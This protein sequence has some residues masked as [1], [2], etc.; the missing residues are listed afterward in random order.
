MKEKKKMFNDILGEP[1]EKQTD[2][3]QKPYRGKVNLAPKKPKRKKA[4]LRALR[5]TPP[6]PAEIEEKCDCGDC[7]CEKDFIDGFCDECGSEWEDCICEDISDLLGEEIEN[8]QEDP[9]DLDPSQDISQIIT[10]LPDFLR[11]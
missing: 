11:R 3:G 8:L 10:Y 5:S 2:D 9:W 1:E 4:K 6:V 7:D